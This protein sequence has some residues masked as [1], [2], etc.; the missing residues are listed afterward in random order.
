M[1]E[2]ILRVDMSRLTIK[3]EKVKPDYLLLGGRSLTSTIINDE[4]SPLCHPLGKN[5]KLIFATG[6]LTGTRAPSSGRISIGAKSPLTGG[7][8]E[9]NAGGVTS[10]KLARLGI[11][12][13]VV[14]GKPQS[15]ETY[16]LL[17]TKQG[18]TLDNKPSWK[19]L[20]TNKLSEEIYSFYGDNVGLI[21][22]GPA[23]EMRMCA[24]GISNNDINKIPSRYAARGGLGAVMG[25]KGLKAIVIDDTGCKGVPVKDP[26]AFTKAAKELVRALKEHEV[27]NIGLRA[28]GTADLIEYIDAIGA[29]PTRN[30]REGQFEAASKVTGA[31]MAQVVE[32]RKGKGKMGHPCSPGCIIQCSNIYPDKDGEIICSPIEY[33]SIW[34]LGPNLGIGDLDIIARLNAACND[35]GL[36]TIE[37]GGTLG[38]L[39]DAGLLE[40]GDGKGAMELLS[41]VEKGSPIGRIVGMGVEGAGKAYGVNRVP[42]V[43]GQGIPAYDPRGI[44]GL[45]VTYATS[46]MGADHT[47]GHT[48]HQEV[49]KIGGDYDPLTV[50]G[51]GA[52]SY[53]RQVKTAFI[54]STGLCAFVTLSTQDLP[55]GDRAIIDLI[56]AKYGCNWTDEDVIKYGKEI[57]RIEREFNKL[58]GLT[59]SHDRL[60]EF[61]LEEPLPPHNHVFDVPGV[62]L[63]KVARSGQ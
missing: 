48:G 1:G 53:D 29:L 41:E 8:K 14:E 30:F 35:I 42:V 34:A 63:N 19:G 22:I 17:I 13:L 10:R 18:I 40:F 3:K 4:V 32:Q 54:D 31:Y 12:A 51:K 21:C 49:F 33:E 5:N 52:L 39:M 44:K 62:E 47:A 61:M 7:I 37:T 38:V 2:C 50:E 59:K 24:A 23:G 26:D 43:K 55:Y 20:G 6:L 36:D 57:L 27:T 58:A 45:G 46:T 9:A 60:P 16:I 28:L 15:A 25:S 11:K 56:N